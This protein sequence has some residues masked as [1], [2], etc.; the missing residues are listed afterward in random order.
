MESKA[1]KENI[2]TGAADEQK[3]GLNE[4][5]DEKA[6]QEQECMERW[7]NS[8]DWWVWGQMFKEDWE[9]KAFTQRE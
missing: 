3:D 9:E 8:N 6:E 5:Q 1:A 2:S 7:K 4:L